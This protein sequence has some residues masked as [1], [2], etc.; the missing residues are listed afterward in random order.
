MQQRSKNDSADKLHILQLS[1]AHF[2]VQ[3]SRKELP[4]ITDALAAAAHEQSLVPDLCIFSGDLAFG[5]QR[6]EFNSGAEWLEKIVAKWPG[7]K[8]FVVPGN[9]DVDRNVAKLILR[10]VHDEEKKY[11]A[12]RPSLLK[13]LDHL[14]NFFTWHADWKTR[15][16]P[17]LLSDW[18]GSLGCRAEAVVRGRIV[19][20]VGLNTALLSC[21][22][23]DLHKLTQDIGELNA[24]LG[25]A[26]RPEDCVVAVGHHP[27]HWL[28]GWN[29][30]ETERLLK[31][32]TG[33]NVYLHGHQHEQHAT[34]FSSANGAELAVLESGAAY[35]GSPWPQYFSFWTLDFRAR[36]ICPAVF[37][38]SPSSGEWVPAE[39]LSRCFVAPIPPALQIGEATAAVE[40]ASV[41]LTSAAPNGVAT[42]GASKLELHAAADSPGAA[43]EVYTALRM[44]IEQPGLFKPVLFAIEGEVR[45]ARRASAELGGAVDGEFVNLCAFE[46]V[47][48]FHADVPAVVAAVLERFPAWLPPGSR[49]QFERSVVI[50]LQGGRPADDPLALNAAIDEMVEAWRKDGRVVVQPPGGGVTAAVVAFQCAETQVRQPARVVPVRIR[51][52]SAT[53]R[54]WQHLQERLRPRAA[55][56][57]A[58]A[59]RRLAALG[60][61]FDA[62]IQSI[63]V[64]KELG[65]GVDA[66]PEA[67]TPSERSLDTPERQL[68][69]LAGLPP[70]IDSQI[71]QAYEMWKQAD[72]SQQVRGAE[73]LFRKAADAFLPLVEGCPDEVADRDLSRRLAIIARMERALMLLRTDN[74]ADLDEACRIYEQ[75]TGELPSDP[76][77]LFRFGQALARLGRPEQAVPRFTQTLE[78]LRSAGDD[79]DTKWLRDIT[80][81]HLAIAHFRRFEGGSLSVPDRREAIRRATELADA[82]LA[83]TKD[84]VMRR[85]ALNDLVYYAWEE[86]RV[87]AGTDDPATLSAERFRELGQWFDQELSQSANVTFREYDTLARLHV[88]LA[89]REPA[90]VAAQKVCDDLEKLAR[91]RSADG[92]PDL[93]SKPRYRAGWFA[94]VWQ[95]MRSADEKGALLYAFELL[96]QPPKPPA[97]RLS[98]Q[99]ADRPG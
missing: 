21:D 35:Q 14:R 46:I 28:I 18:S 44:A 51:V 34:T 24:A 40:A 56:R 66:V 82:V 3:D 75:I 17:R 33:A 69:L 47:T 48:M 49:M 94:E 98:R 81:L 53:E 80:R 67:T 59:Q 37:G 10:K 96:E 52:S 88:E 79:A 26:C 93:A 62:L 30:D 16:G 61:H 64:L 97:R 84:P 8:L 1:D 12:L 7:C 83:E 25:H 15:L 86:R 63:E 91:G 72:A 22:D 9:H 54:F 85:Y 2:G 87:V 77:P 20:I 29:R 92:L 32:K 36:E 76:K 68:Q 50:N 57:D 55:T 31:Q 70:R 45:P 60:M 38:Y 41:A 74:P 43:E 73:Q 95:H 42:L 90:I 27:L 19:H 71:R 58:T 78:L 13:S 6:H 65:H 39:L 23:E 11:S 4:R 5:G 89:S 99:A